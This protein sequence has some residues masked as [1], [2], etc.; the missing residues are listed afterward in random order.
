[1]I[2]FC[3]SKLLVEKD[4]CVFTFLRRRSTTL[5]RYNFSQGAYQT[6]GDLAILRTSYSYAPTKYYT[7]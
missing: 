2:N 5:K 1:M 3:F 7:P 4:I 6:Q